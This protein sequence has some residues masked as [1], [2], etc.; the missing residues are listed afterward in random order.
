MIG[1]YTP[2][3]TTQLAQQLYKN[4][5]ITLDLITGDPA[6][7]NKTVWAIGRNTDAGQRYAAFGE[8]GLGV[9]AKT[10]QWFPTYSTAQTVNGTLTY[11][12]V[13]GSHQP[14][15]V[16]QQ[17]GQI[18]DPLGAGGYNSG[19]KVAEAL[20]ATLASDAFKGKYIDDNDEVAYTYPNATAGYYIGYITPGDANNRL[21]GNDGILPVAN[22]GVALTYNGVAN[23]SANVRSG[24]YTVWIY[25]RLL[26]SQTALTGVKLAFADALRDQIKNVDAPAGGGIFNDSSVLVERFTDGG[27][28]LKKP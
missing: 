4:G 10:S 9:A 7:A 26:R 18:A 13:V 6:D 23:T 14:W 24:R 16:N 28:V 3:I 1:A 25:N 17:V 11:G 2:N 27:L 20:T 8:I 5:S 22:R 12:G 21:L 15:P 19:Q